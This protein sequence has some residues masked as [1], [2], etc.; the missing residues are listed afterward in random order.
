MA[1][2]TFIAGRYAGTYNAVD[3]GI[4]DDGYTLQQELMQ[5]VIDES[6]AFGGTMLDYIYRGGNAFMRFTSKAYKP[7]SVS[8]FWPFGALGVGMTTAAPIGR[9]ASNI[10]A[11][12]VLT[13]VANTPAAAAPASLTASLAILAPNYSG[14]LLYNSK[15]RKVPVRLQFLPSVSTGTLTWFTMT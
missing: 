6:D 11:A 12:M 7:G 14:E 4:T 13:A 2:D 8:P 1:L 5:E 3:V 9:L 15:L 10:A